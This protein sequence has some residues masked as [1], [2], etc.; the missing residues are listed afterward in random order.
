MVYCGDSSYLDLVLLLSQGS[1]FDYTHLLTVTSS[2]YPT[3]GLYLT[4]ALLSHLGFEPHQGIIPITL[5]RIVLL[6]C[7]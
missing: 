4:R 7:K 5:Y 6:V 2:C 3:W 1:N